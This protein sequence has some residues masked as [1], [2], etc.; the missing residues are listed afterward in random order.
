MENKIEIDVT[1]GGGTGPTGPEP[2]D[3]ELQDIQEFENKYIG[4][5]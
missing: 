1:Y 3:Q 4:R 2:D 5:I